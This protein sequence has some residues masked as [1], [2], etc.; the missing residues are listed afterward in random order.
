ISA[1]GPRRKG[2]FPSL[3]CFQILSTFTV[4]WDVFENYFANSTPSGVGLKDLRLQLIGESVPQLQAMSA[5]WDALANLYLQ[6]ATSMPRKL[7][8][9]DI[10]WISRYKMLTS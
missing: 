3:I 5:L 8:A 7:S 4:F 1:N 10:Q 2:K 9:H 6:F